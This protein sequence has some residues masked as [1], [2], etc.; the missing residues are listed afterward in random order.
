MASTT[1]TGCKTSTTLAYKL[2]IRG[3]DC[4]C[5]HRG[6]GAS[7]HMHMCVHT[8][9]N[10]HAMYISQ[11][12]LHL[13]LP[14]ALPPPSQP[15]ACSPPLSLLP[16]NHQH[17]PLSSPSSLTTTSMLPYALPRPLQPPACS[18]LRSLLPHN[19]QHAMKS[20]SQPPQIE[21]KGRNAIPPNIWHTQARQHQTLQYPTVKFPLTTS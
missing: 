17:A 11:E 13:T 7:R 20:S 18:P 10:V 14:S 8:H 4:L 19:H 9:T 12:S 5:K 1:H 2:Y 21:D 3:Y 16:H 6:T 15:P